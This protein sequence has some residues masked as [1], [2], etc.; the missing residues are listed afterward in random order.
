M[1]P[2]Q[3]HQQ[4]NGGAAQHP[5]TA[6]RAF[7]YLLSGA[8]GGSLPPS[9]ALRPLGSGQ[10]LPTARNRKDSDCCAAGIRN[11]QRPCPVELWVT[12]GGCGQVCGKAV[13][14]FAPRAARRASTKRGEAV[15]GLSTE[16]STA[17]FPPVIHRSAA[18]RSLGIPDLQQPTATVLAPGG[19][20]APCAR[21][22]WE[23]AAIRPTVANS[24]R[25][26]APSLGESHIV[27]RSARES[28]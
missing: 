9:R 4:S 26:A 1:K 21:G 7:P 6:R 11:L 23:A 8:D 13:V 20:A 16:L 14:R 27:F 15:H 19:S 25:P 5:K 17:G 24:T 3:R 10:T 2:I 18:P 12:G 28:Q 22:V